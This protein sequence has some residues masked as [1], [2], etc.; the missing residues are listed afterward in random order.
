MSFRVCSSSIVVVVWEEKEL[1][2]QTFSTTFSRYVNFAPGVALGPRLL[3]E[4]PIVV[5]ALGLESHSL[6]KPL[7]V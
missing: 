3:R 2:V 4:A 5:E 1:W 7:H 6:G